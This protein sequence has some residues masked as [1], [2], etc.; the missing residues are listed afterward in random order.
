METDLAA[1]LCFLLLGGETE[2]RQHYSVVGQSHH[3]RVDCETPGQV[4]EVGLD[5]RASIDS[6][7]Q[8]LFAAVRTGKEPVIWIIDTDGREGKF[9]YQIK[10][11]AQQV[12]VRYES[13]PINYL[14][15]WQMTEY[16]RNYRAQP[17][18]GF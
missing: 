2:T 5:K 6:L 12:G 1:I 7:H 18:T 3:V 8:A 13:I 4:I 15:R 16:L 11:V 10:T 14:V 17:V 9:E